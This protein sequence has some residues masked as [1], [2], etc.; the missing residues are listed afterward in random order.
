V[1]H[2]DQNRNLLRVRAEPFA[3]RTTVRPTSA[4]SAKPPAFWR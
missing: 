2:D 1:G 3:C 4:F